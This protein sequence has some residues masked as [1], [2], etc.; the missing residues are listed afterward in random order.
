MKKRT[1]PE[2]SGVPY[3]TLVTY[4]SKE[5]LNSRDELIN[6]E[7]VDGTEV[8]ELV[9]GWFARFDGGSIEEAEL[10]LRTLDFL[11]AHTPAG[12]KLDRH[13]A[14]KLLVLRGRKR[15]GS[16]YRALTD[17]EDLALRLR[18]ALH[19]P[20]AASFTCPLLG[21]VKAI[22]KHVHS[23]YYLTTDSET[24]ILERIDSVFAYELELF[25]HIVQCKKHKEEAPLELLAD[26]PS[27][28]KELYALYD[29]FLAEVALRGLEV[30]DASSD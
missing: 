11:I 4:A 26:P 15:L 7:G 5:F 19:S 21:E 23:E 24:E 2:P 18:F 28:L 13:E 20:L 9:S 14:A 25:S 8:L 27:D 10:T 6:R 1:F 17:F 29:D 16:L 22:Q 3:S 12:T 30:E